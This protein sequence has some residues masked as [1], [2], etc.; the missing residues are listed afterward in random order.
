MHPD[1]I[2]KLRELSLLLDL[3]Y[4]HYFEGDVKKAKSAEGTIR[5]E[6]GNFWYR[7]NNPA[8]PPAAP[9]IESVVIYSSIF[10]AARVTYFDDLDEAIQTVREWYEYQKEANEAA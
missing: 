8:I 7:K 1:D 6:F 9:E 3:A 10:S 4:L 2:N 5:L